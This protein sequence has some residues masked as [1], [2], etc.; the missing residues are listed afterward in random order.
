[1][2]RDISAL[3]EKEYDLIIIGGGIFGACAAWDAAQRG[4]SVALVERGDFSHATSANHF[5]IVHGGIR[6]LQHGDLYRVR[7]SSRERSALL[8]IAPHLVKPLPIV[9]PTYGHGLQGKEL[10]AIG[11]FLYDLILFDRNR[12]L[13]DPARKIPSSRFISKEECLRLFPDL[14]KEGLTGAAIFCDGQ[15]YNPPRLALSFLRSAVDAGAQIANYVEAIEF[16]HS[17]NRVYGIKARDTLTGEEFQIRG[18]IVLNAAGPWAEQLL[19]TQPNLRRRKAFTFSRDACFIVGRRLIEDYTL[20]VQVGTSDPDA[21]LSRGQRHVFIAPWRN[22]TLIG[23]W[24]KVHSGDPDTFTVT[25]KDLL[26]FLDEVNSAYPSFDLSFQD[27]TQW[28]AGLTLFG[29]NEAGAS[30]LSFGKRSQLIDHFKESNVQ[31]LITLIGVRATT[32]RGVAEKAVN[33]AVRKLGKKV[34]RSKT[35]ITPIYGGRIRNFEEFT[36]DIIKNR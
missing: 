17:C 5:K 28:N 27:I 15:I 3:T 30:N 10:L 25:E 1:M 19:K 18:K 13:S 4:L 20:A 22:Y 26:G 29:E 6:Y 9:V 11:L 24:H 31:G 36:K 8:R 34:P 12:G 32:A 33:L 21:I 16:L 2:N 35:A 7:E 14:K 23:V